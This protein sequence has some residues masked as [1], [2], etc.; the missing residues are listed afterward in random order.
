[1]SG[2]II[3]LDDSD[4]SSSDSIPSPSPFSTT[5]Y[6]RPEPERNNNKTLAEPPEAKR[7][8]VSVL[9]QVQRPKDDVEEEM[10]SEP[11]EQE[12]ASGGQEEPPSSRAPEIESVT[13]MRRGRNC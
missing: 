11:T 12:N 2:R 5:S 6:Q 7:Q 8:R 3:I 1:M 10:L 9:E 13:L 4:G